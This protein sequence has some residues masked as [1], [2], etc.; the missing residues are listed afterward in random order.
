VLA[1]AL[2]MG[3]MNV[4]I[5]GAAKL[6]AALAQSGA[7]PR[8]LAADAWRS[9]PRRPLAVI[10]VAG[11][12]LLAGLV[13]GIGDAGDLVRATSALFIAVYVLALLSAIRILDGR[14]RAAAAFAFAASLVL[15]A[16]SGWYLAVPLAAA[17]AWV[18]SRRVLSG[19]SGSVRVQR[20]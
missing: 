17:V 19:F 3:T 7:L 16:F 8:A 4:Y 13:A 10:A 15:A 18:G 6:S 20:S 9:V 12:P 2:T 1:V 14:V 5:A 11:V